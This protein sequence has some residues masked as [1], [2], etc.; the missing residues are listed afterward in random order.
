VAIVGGFNAYR[1]RS[2][3]SVLFSTNELLGEL[4]IPDSI[5]IEDH[6]E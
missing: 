5:K 6:H 2:R 4:E 3:F 1:R